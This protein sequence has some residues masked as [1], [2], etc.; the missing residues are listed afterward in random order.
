MRLDSGSET[1]M[2][3]RVRVSGFC[4]AREVGPVAKG[5]PMHQ[6]VRVSG[7]CYPVAILRWG[8]GSPLEN[9]MRTNSSFLLPACIMQ[10][11]IGKKAASG[12]PIG[13]GDV[14]AVVASGRA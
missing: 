11:L 10:L 6:R 7:F 2:H 13:I 9:G 8:R 3:Q 5:G 1:G 4:Y 12:C 14:R